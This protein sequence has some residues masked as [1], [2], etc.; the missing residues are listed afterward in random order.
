MTWHVIFTSSYSANYCKK[1]RPGGLDISEF[2]TS[3]DVTFGRVH[4][5]FLKDLDK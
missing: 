2:R 3:V 1:L 4:I 5:F